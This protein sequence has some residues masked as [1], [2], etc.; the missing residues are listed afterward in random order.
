MIERD[1]LLEAQAGVDGLGGGAFLSGKR[2]FGRRSDGFSA[3]GF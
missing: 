1:G 3:V 2:R